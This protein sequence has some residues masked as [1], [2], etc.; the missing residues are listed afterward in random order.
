MGRAMIV[1]AGESL[2]DMVPSGPGGFAAHCGGGPFNTARTLARLGRRVG[3]LGAISDDALGRRLRQALEADGVSLDLVVETSLPTTLAFA[4]LSDD[5]SASY[6]FYTE[7]TSVPGLTATSALAVLPT[8]PEAVHVGSLG[9]MLEPIA[10]AVMAVTAAAA[11][12]GALVMFDPNIRPTLID[13]RGAYLERFERVVASADVVKASI[14]DLAWV[15]A[16][17]PAESVARRLLATGAARVVLMTRGAEGAVAFSGGAA[18]AVP[19][20]PVRVVDTIGAG[21]AFSAGFLA[22]WLDRG[23][24]AAQLGDLVAICEA[25]RFAC[26]VASRTCERSGADPPR[27]AELGGA[28][29]LWTS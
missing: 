1:V 4:E 23:L 8:A 15:G 11:A 21:D 25:A 10:D 16:G 24:G 20:P 3:F 9:L 5:G 13:D 7:G 28:G 6:R 12:R 2:V 17:E 18:V 22:W 26:L 14:E 19:A 29:V 27:R